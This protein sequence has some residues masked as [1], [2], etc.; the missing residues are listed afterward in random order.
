MQVPVSYLRWL[1]SYSLALKLNKGMLKLISYFFTYSLIDDT[2][3]DLNKM[4]YYPS[5][6]FIWSV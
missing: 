6:W 3:V 4:R 2:L 5:L 1:P